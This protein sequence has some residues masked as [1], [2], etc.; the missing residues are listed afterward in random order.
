[1]SVLTKNIRN[2]V[3]LSHSGAGK[4]TLV[5]NLVFKGGSISKPGSVNSG[6]TVSDYSDDEKKRKNSINLSVAF[7]DKDG[8]KVNLLD[9]PGYL[10]YI[11]DVASGINAAD[12]AVF[13]I[14]AVGGIQVGTTKFW[15]L[16]QVKSLPGIIV[17][18]KMDKDN[19]DFQKILEAVKKKF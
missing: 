9:A 19:A 15:K 17:V 13:I 11:G 12:A 3:F 16:A 4:T 6:T 10:D 5:E 14:D 18:N 1:M 7:Y 8:V 2:I